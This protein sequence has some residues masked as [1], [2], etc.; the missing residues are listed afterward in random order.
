MIVIIGILV[1]IDY[2]IGRDIMYLG[3]GE[4]GM[5]VLVKMGRML[6]VIVMYFV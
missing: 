1:N 3:V 2:V 4:L 6:Y 5:I